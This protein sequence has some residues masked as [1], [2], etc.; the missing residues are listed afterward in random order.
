[1]TE[2]DETISKNGTHLGDLDDLDSGSNGTEPVVADLDATD[3]VDAVPTPPPTFQTELA[4]AMQSVAGRERERI[5]ADVA[6]DASTQVERAKA[7][8]AAEAEAFRLVADEDIAE[9]EAWADREVERIR[10]DAAERIA[11]RRSDLELSLSQQEEVLRTEIEG[12]D[13]AVVEYGQTLDT[14]FEDLSVETDPEVIARRA[15]SLP[16]RPDIEAVRA[17]ARAEAL[18]RIAEQA[19]GPG[20]GA[21]EIAA[22]EDDDGATTVASEASIEIDGSSGEPIV[23]TG[24]EIDPEPSG[25]ADDD[26]PSVE[27]GVT[28]SPELSSLAAM[29]DGWS[30]TSDLGGLIGTSTDDS[31]STPSFLTAPTGDA[32][33]AG[34][35]ARTGW[36]TEP[37]AIG[38]DTSPV[39]VMDPDATAPSTWPSEVPVE[40]PAEPATFG[41]P[42]AAVRLIRSVAPW[43]APTRT[44]QDAHDPHD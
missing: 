30:D 39:A 34:V 43:T 26:E 3:A 8:A 7:D 15:G 11:G 16:R 5:A 25:E 14:Y 38:D 19:A 22:D 23:A 37:S 18:T 42:N 29:S 31:W 20:E 44:D 32:S 6:E 28:P 35:E 4:A 1:M 21:G 24:D 41:H 2:I 13:A 10:A 17:V 12:V 9:I 27:I 36:E 33:P 40:H